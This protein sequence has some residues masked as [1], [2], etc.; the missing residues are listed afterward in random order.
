MEQGTLPRRHSVKPHINLTMTLEGLKGE[1]GVPPADLDLSLPISIK[2]AER[3]ACDCTMS[4]VVLA[5]SMVIDVG[6]ATRTV[7]P[8]TMRALRVRDRGCRF[9]G[10]DR[11]V[12]WS[13]PHHLIYW[14]RGGPGKL[15][16]LVLL[17]YFHHRLVHEG[18]WQVVK[19]GPE[20]KFLP[21]DRVAMRRARGPG[22]RWAA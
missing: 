16:N 3:I 2:T 8:P 10:C 21:P 11:Q 19:A 22:Y 13:S 6:R 7:S 4:R 1:L 12:S 14:S 15:P 20:F 17:C 5:D 9:P 18:G